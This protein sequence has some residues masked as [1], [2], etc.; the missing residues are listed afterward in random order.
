MDLAEKAMSANSSTFMP[1]PSAVDCRK[2]PLPAEH[3]VFS[4]KSFNPAVF[5][6]DELNILAAHIDDDVRVVVELERRFGVRDCLDER[7]IRVQHVLED[8]LRIAGRSYPQ[9]LER[10]AFAL[11]LL[12]QLLEHLDPI[13]DRIAVGK[14]VGL[15]KDLALFVQQDGLGGCGTAIDAHKAGDH[16]AGQKFRGNEL[17][18][19]VFLLKLLEL[20]VFC[21][22]A[23]AT[24]DGLFLRAAVIDVVQQLLDAEISAHLRL[25]VLA[26]FDRAQSREVLRVLRHLDQLFR[27]HP[28]RDLDLALL[29]H[30]RNICLPCLAHALE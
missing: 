17:L 24:G 30:A 14:L 3:W 1:K 20:G 2:Y 21:D 6:D 22:Q 7:D 27:L 19:A 13:L 18:L 10:S 29:P 28:L 12:A 5:K 8:V 4:L 25:F 9:H 23:L 16:L 11:D 26:E 15:A